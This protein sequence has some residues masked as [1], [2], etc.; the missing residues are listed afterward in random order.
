MTKLRRV[1]ILG[2]G[3]AVPDRVLTNQE[4]ERMVDTSD[5]WIVQRTGIKERRIADERTATS[6]ICI[7]ASSKALD[8]S[9]VDPKDLDLI[10]VGTVTPDMFFPSTACVVQDAIGAVNG[11][12][13]DVSAA[14]CG[15]VYGLTIASQFISN[16]AYERI[17]V[18]G[19]EMLSKITNY[20]ERD[21]CVLFGDGGGAAVLGAV[22][23]PRGILAT[24]VGS[25]GG[26]G[27]LLSLPAGGSRIPA[28]HDTVDQGL[29][30]IRM[31]GR[32]LYGNAV[33][34]MSE[35]ALRVLGATGYSGADLDLLIP[36]QANLRMIARTAER[37]ELPMEKV[38]VNVDRLGNTSAGSIPIA[39]DEAVR[40]GLIKEGM[41]ICMTAFGGG[42]TWGSVLIRW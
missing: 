8:M 2:T 29:H 33:K 39:L 4:L 30:Y 14:C 37:L 18:L 41:L 25:D 32:A 19:A 3:S 21:T 16:G 36:H 31:N 11:A 40:A 24:D 7:Q 38:Y 34:A 9:G 35:S 20:K 42:L 27:K 5:E 12:A 23:E 28:S 6:D 22:E 13:F 1:G 15:F 10:I 26:L 17:L